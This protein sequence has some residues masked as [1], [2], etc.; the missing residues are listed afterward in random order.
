MKFIDAFRT[1]I[2]SLFANKLRSFLT[3][4]G[5]IIGVGAVIGLMS[6]GRGAEARIASS[7][8]QLGTNALYVIPR[9]PEASG[10][11]GLM[12]GFTTAT[13]SLKDAET[14]ADAVDGQAVLG[15]APASE[16]IAEI[17]AGSESFAAIVSGVTPDYQKVRNHYVASGEFIS[18]RNVRSREMVVVLGSETAEE[19]FGS[20]DPIGETVKIKGRRFNVIGV[21]EP[22]GSVAMGISLD[23]VAM[24]PLT[25]FQSRLFTQR[26]TRGEDAVQSIA[27]QVSG[28]EVID[29]VTWQVETVLRQRHRIAA[30]AKND[31]GIISQ[32]EVLGMFQQ[33]TGVFTIFLG[34]VAGISLLVGGI[35]IMN[36]ML[37]SVTERTREIGVRK[38]IG[39]K[40][41]DILLQFL[42]EAAALSFTGGAIGI[43]GGWLLSTVVSH[44]DFGGGITIPAVVSPDIVI[45][46]ATVSILVGL[47]SGIYPAIRA[48][49]LNPIDALHYG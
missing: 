44:I 15:I 19:L 46:A 10:I 22:K 47:A 8:E 35:G 11:A 17:T 7:F 20:R 30:D 3:M 4:L 18:D 48:S 28:P 31:F 32:Q 36:I 14:I 2:R 37:V 33:I 24:V 29:D 9:S 49:R 16:N 45:L 5:V 25:T 12:G 13:L 23:R 40:R 42:Y 34:A 39:G 27:I 21:L 1:A 41:R 6:V 26:T 43:V 38:A